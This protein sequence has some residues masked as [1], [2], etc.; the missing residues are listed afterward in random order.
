[1][2]QWPGVGPATV[3]ALSLVADLIYGAPASTRDPAMYSFAHGGKDGYPYPVD[4]KGYDRTIAI[5]GNAVRRAKL[6]DRDKVDALR[7]LA[8]HY[9]A[10]SL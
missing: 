7:R 4:R 3:R 9:G 6:G 10:D 2:L 1:M 8:V 5:L